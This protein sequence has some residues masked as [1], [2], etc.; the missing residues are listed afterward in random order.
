MALSLAGAYEMGIRSM[1]GGLSGGDFKYPSLRNCPVNSC[2]LKNGWLC[3][4]FSAEWDGALKK[5]PTTLRV[6]PVSADL[7]VHQGS[8]G[9]G[10]ECVL[11]ISGITTVV[12]LLLNFWVLFTKNRDGQLTEFWRAKEM[13]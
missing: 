4:N 2:G 10:K 12:S 8:F 13:Y 3:E 1:S 9:L 6:K 5:K 7:P 11:Q